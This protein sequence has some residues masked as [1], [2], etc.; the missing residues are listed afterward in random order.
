M[1]SLKRRVAELEAERDRYREA[2]KNAASHH[3]QRQM[4]ESGTEDAEY[5]EERRNVLLFHL[6][7]M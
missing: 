3:H 5:H 2:I 1:V 6:N 7:L 4:F